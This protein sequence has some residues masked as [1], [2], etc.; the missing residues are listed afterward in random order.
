[1][2]IVERGGMG[3]TDTSICSFGSSSVI[4]G[5][6]SGMSIVERGGMGGTDTSICSFGSSS[7]I[8]GGGMSIVERGGMGDTDTS[9]CSFGFNSSVGVALVAVDSWEETLGGITGGEQDVGGEGGVKLG[10]DDLGGRVGGSEEKF[11][12]RSG[13]GSIGGGGGI[14]FGTK[15]LGGIFGGLGGNSDK[16]GGGKSGVVGMGGGAYGGGRCVLGG[17]R[18]GASTTGSYDVTTS[19]GGVVIDVGM[20][21]N[22]GVVIDV[23]LTSPFNKS[24]HDERHG[25]IEDGKSANVVTL[26]GKLGGVS[27]EVGGV[28]SWLFLAVESL[29]GSFIE[30]FLGGGGGGTNSGL[31][32]GDVV[33]LAA[34]PTFS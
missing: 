23:V 16:G 2:S 27:G 22:V 30:D 31:R 6:G 3:G 20:T 17:K 7:V 32:T 11:T 34:E 5:G 26:G 25:W 19:L 1:M 21:V 8:R 14:K 29:S 24:S 15:S 13:G 18:G 12:G 10:T 4:R 9:I 28:I 33:G